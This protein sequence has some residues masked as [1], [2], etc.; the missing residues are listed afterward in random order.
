M[1]N[2]RAKALVEFAFVDE[3]RYDIEAH[4]L[5]YDFIENEIGHFY[6]AD[7]WIKHREHYLGLLGTWL[8]ARAREDK[9]E[10][11]VD[12]LDELAKMGLRWSDFDQDDF[13]TD[14]DIRKLN[15][16]EKEKPRRGKVLQPN[17]TRRPGPA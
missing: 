16:P 14:E 10:R 4:D 7:S 17:P 2:S 9:L 11:V 1:P 3:P 15:E 6:F 8:N 12:E 5:A 13:L